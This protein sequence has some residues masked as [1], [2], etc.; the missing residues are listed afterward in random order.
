MRG[1]YNKAFRACKGPNRRLHVGLKTHRK[2]PTP[3]S[4]AA[5]FCRPGGSR[6][7]PDPSD[8]VI[9]RVPGRTSGRA[10]NSTQP[11]KSHR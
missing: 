9:P 8:F 6:R 2:V 7:E 1:A 10:A 5:I 4:L 11:A 3:Q